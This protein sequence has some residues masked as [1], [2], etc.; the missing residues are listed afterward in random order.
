[1]AEYPG[2]GVFIATDAPAL[3]GQ[4]CQSVTAKDPGARLR[5]LI[6]IRAGPYRSFTC[7]AMIGRSVQE[8][9]R[10]VMLERSVMTAAPSSR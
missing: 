2:S 10:Q 4:Q 7:M 5:G 6:P 1:M 3:P 8:Q 9:G